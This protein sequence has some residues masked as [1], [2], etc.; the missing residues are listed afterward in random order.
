MAVAGAGDRKKTGLNEMTVG[1]RNCGDPVQKPCISLQTM[2]GMDTH[3]TDAAL[4]V[5]SS[6]DEVYH[7]TLKQG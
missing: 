6:G 2:T 1:A 7:P 3:K 5:L 4:S